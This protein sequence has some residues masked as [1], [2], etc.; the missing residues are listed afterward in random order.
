MLHAA[1]QLV[2]LVGP[3]PVP[4]QMAPPLPQHLPLHLI[5]HGAGPDCAS[6]NRQTPVARRPGDDPLHVE[7]MGGFYVDF[8][9]LSL[10]FSS[11]P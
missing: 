5:A 6:W 11:C 3:A 2:A 4:W 7:G 8:G 9:S 1:E 10:L